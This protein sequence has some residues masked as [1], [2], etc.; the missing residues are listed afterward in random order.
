MNL[1]IWGIY[2]NVEINPSYIR[3]H[4]QNM[5]NTAISLVDYKAIPFLIG[6]LLCPPKT[7]I[8]YHV[9]KV[10]WL[11]PFPITGN[12]HGRVTDPKG[13]HLTV[14]IWAEG[15]MKKVFKK[16]ERLSKAIPSFMLSKLNHIFSCNFRF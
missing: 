2:S 11:C 14:E 4:A 5:T 15:S 7:S 6:P 3:D 10:I 9:G 8:M 12:R 13:D 16:C 1:F